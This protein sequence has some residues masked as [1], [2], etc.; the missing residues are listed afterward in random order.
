MYLHHVYLQNNKSV[1][2]G[3]IWKWQFKLLFI[4]CQFVGWFV[5]GITQK[6]LNWFPWYSPPEK[7]SAHAFRMADLKFVLE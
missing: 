5:R 4:L 1:N 6:L 2:S 3:S 7:K